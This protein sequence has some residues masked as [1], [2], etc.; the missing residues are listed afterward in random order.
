M[1]GSKILNFLSGKSGAA[2]ASHAAQSS[3]K[4]QGPATS[5]HPASGGLKEQLIAAQ[6]KSA[7]DFIREVTAMDA[8]DRFIISLAQRVKVF[9]QVTDW[10][11]K[12]EKLMGGAGDDDPAGIEMMKNL[13]GGVSSG[14]TDKVPLKRRPGRPTKTEAAA[15]KL[16]SDAYERNHRRKTGAKPA[17]DSGLQKML[18]GGK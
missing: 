17:D 11:M 13:L 15:H 8:D 7:L 14:A 10:L 1:L 4:T 5:P 12:R 2:P 9:D 18:M 3:P 6:D 16:M